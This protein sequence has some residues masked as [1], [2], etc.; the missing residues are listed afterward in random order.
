MR[1]GYMLAILITIL[2]FLALNTVGLVYLNHERIADKQYQTKVN[3]LQF[4][5][6]EEITR[7]FLSLSH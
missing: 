1:K 2:I 4:A 7:L 3:N 5:V 6:D